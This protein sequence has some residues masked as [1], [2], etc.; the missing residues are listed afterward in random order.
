LKFYSKIGIHRLTSSPSLHY[1]GRA[2]RISFRRV[3]SVS[4]CRGANRHVFT[5]EFQS[6][7]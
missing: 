5:D 1:L 4:T 3:V 2:C 6:I 7:L